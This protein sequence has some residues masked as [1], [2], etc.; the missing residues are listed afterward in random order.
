VGGPDGALWFGQDS[1]GQQLGRIT[2]GGKAI[3]F[4]WPGPMPLALT[5]GPD[6]SV[7]FV[8]Q[9]LP[10][11]EYGRQSQTGGAEWGWPNSELSGIVAGPDG[12]MWMTNAYYPGSIARTTTEGAVIES[13]SIPTVASDPGSIVAGPDGNLWFLET[14]VNQIAR[15]STAGDFTEFPLNV[16][17]G[18]PTDLAV[19]PDGNLWVSESNDFLARVTTAGSVTAYHV[20]SSPDSVAAGWDGTIWY[21][22]SA[23]NR[24]GHINTDGTGNVEFDGPPDAPG[25][26]SMTAGPDGNMW[27]A[28]SVVGF[29]RVGKVSD[30]TSKSFHSMVVPSGF[31]PRIVRVAGPGSLMTWGFYGSTAASATDATGL[32][33]FDSGPKLPVSF[34]SYV[35]GAA[36]T[37]PY[38]DSLAPTHTGSVQVP[39]RVALSQGMTDQADVLWSTHVAMGSTVFDVQVEQPGSSVFVDWLIDQ[40][41]RSQSFGPSDPLYVGPGT[42]TFRARMRD[43]L[44]G[45]ASGYSPPRSVV[46]G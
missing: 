42:Y 27:F 41:G 38:Q 21:T 5:D 31:S 39:V 12:S 36:G 28:E 8:V 6:G 43:A 15:M 22:A 29:A 45:A 46:L 37:F 11:S 4:N 14:A 20:A 18:G 1:G 30:E 10:T 23:D 17:A 33:L 2:I 24:I 16:D 40:S 25:V 35:F 26:N 7:W 34:S 44:T 13:F 3:E 32:G 9:I 19:G